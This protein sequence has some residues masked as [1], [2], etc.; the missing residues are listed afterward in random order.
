MGSSLWRNLDAVRN[1][2]G[3]IVP[4]KPY[5]FI[6]NPP[7]A[8]RL[9]G[10]YWLGNLLYPVPCGYIEKAQEYYSLFYRYNLSRGQAESILRI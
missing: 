9:I 5:S 10:I 8:N 1:G 7:A 3:Y 4:S 6:D 2:K